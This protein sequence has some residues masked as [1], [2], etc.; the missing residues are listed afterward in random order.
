MSATCRSCH[1]PIIWGL[2]AKT[3][4]R[5]PVNEE[6]HALGQ[7]LLRPSPEHDEPLVYH[8]STTPPDEGEFHY[9]SHFATCPQAGDWRRR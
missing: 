3:G 9:V 6:P 7:L 1:A 4:S 5:I 8:A 2:S